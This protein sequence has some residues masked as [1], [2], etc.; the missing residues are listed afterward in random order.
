MRANEKVVTYGLGVN[1][2]GKV[3]GTTEGLLEEFGASRVFETPTSELALTGVGV[4]MA[5]A[6]HPVIHSHQ[7]MDFALLAMDQLVNSAAKW[8][9]MFGD[10]FSVPYL[11]RMIIGRGW[12]QGP[13]HSQNFESWLAHVPGIRVLV[14]AT[15][16]DLNDSIRA[17]ENTEDPIVIIEHRWLHSVSG[18]VEVKAPTGLR[19]NSK[20]HSSLS[21][22]QITIVTWGLASFDCLAAQKI[23]SAEGVKA[24][25]I[26]LREL[27]VEN[28]DVIRDSVA[29]SGRLL[30]ASNSWGPGSFG[31]TVTA[32][33]AKHFGNKDRA[34]QMSC[35]SYPHS[36]EP[37]SLTQLN[38]FH[39]SDW[40]VANA[41]LELLGHKNR[42]SPENP[43]D[44]PQGYDFGPF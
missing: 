41:A 13:T 11:A 10:Q 9:F 6:G 33:V 12:G 38:G 17:I 19:L 18:E 43:V 5:I 24:E 21:S 8:K 26:Q 37:T 35:V 23:L 42:F 39:V 2:P 40:R 16:Q 31:D 4:G 27:A 29:N 15:P 22:P 36:P 34:V 14:P 3:F 32:L 25:V 1:D 30:V 28:F 7:R 44:Q 20:I